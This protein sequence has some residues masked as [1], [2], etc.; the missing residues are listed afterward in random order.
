MGAVRVFQ[1]EAVEETLGNG[2]RIFIIPNRKAPVVSV[3]AF[4]QVGSA[5]EHLG[6]TGISHWVE[7]MLFKG[8]PRFP[9]GQ[10]ARLIQKHGGVLN[11]HTT[12]HHT[13]YFETLPRENWLIG[14]D[15]E[16]D[17][18]L[19]ALF[20]PEE[21]EKERGV[22]LSELEMIENHPEHRLMVQV[23]ATVFQVHPYGFSIIGIRDDLETMTRDDLYEHYLKYYSPDNAFLV[24][25]G[26]VE[27][28]EAFKEV[29]KRF[30]DLPVRPVA[31]VRPAR[32]PAQRGER[33]VTVIG[34][35]ELPLLSIV[36]RGPVPSWVQGLRRGKDQTDV[37]D[38]RPYA[39][40]LLAGVLGQGR[41]SRLYRA[42]VETGKAVSVS[43]S[44]HLMN[45]SGLFSIYVPV[46][47]SA[48]VEEVEKIILEELNR[49]GQEP[50]SEQELSIAKRREAM[51]FLES[52]DSATELAYHIGAFQILGDWRQIND[53]LPSLDRVSPSDLVAAA[54]K[55]F[56]PYNRTVGMFLP[57]GA[58]S[59]KAG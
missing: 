5:H 46:S 18:M 49:L 8:T 17:R 9:K 2:L 10:I 45:D 41:T 14:L 40:R 57:N 20:D 16:A 39:L 27:P 21:T 13:A 7:H 55:T 35:G 11:G 25:S 54:Q 51:D 24:I 43:A 19:N 42:L 47:R 4:Y 56:A 29:E 34:H 38:A 1:V 15:I 59:E 58:S 31:K 22:I 23:M 12:Y 52:L 26:D 28:A 48:S 30:A 37:D 33:R 50:P 6:I 32:E 44:Y 36:F 3:W 53:Y